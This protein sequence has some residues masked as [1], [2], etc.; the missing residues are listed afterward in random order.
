MWHVHSCSTDK[1]SAVD[2]VLK[3]TLWKLFS[4]LSFGRSW[5]PVI[6]WQVSAIYHHSAGDSQSQ[7][8]RFQGAESTSSRDFSTR[9]KDDLPLIL[10]EMQIIPVAK[11]VLF[12]EKRVRAVENPEE[13]QKAGIGGEDKGADSDVT[14]QKLHKAVNK[15]AET[16]DIRLRNTQAAEVLELGGA[17]DLAE[18]LEAAWDVRIEGQDGGRGVKQTASNLAEL[19]ELLSVSIADELSD[20]T[21]RS[22][23]FSQSQEGHVGSAHFCNTQAHC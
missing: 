22:V 11:A 4:N 19:Q 10:F 1:Q 8:Q 3:G 9:G 5:P 23:G 18:Q 12:K 21:E 14:L 6:T 13:V 15:D 16:V 17:T 20:S 2:G 7:A